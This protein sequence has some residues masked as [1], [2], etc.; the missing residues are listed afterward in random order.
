[1][2]GGEPGQN[3]T[4]IEH[5]LSGQGKTPVRCAALL[6]AAAALYVS[7]NGWSFEEAVERGQQSLERG[8]AAAALQRLRAAAP[9]R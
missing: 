6:N 9:R 1:L 3:A 5:L 4:Q 8:A 2:A 7:G